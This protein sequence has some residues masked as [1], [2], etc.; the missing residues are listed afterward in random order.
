MSEK[1][2]VQFID[3]YDVLG[4]PRPNS[5]TM[6]HGQCEGTRIV[7]VHRNDVNDEEGEWRR[8]WLVSE[9]NSRTADDYHFVTCPTCGGSGEHIESR[10]A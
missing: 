2:R 4:I 6:C 7:P 3:R 1:M 8:L 10:T 5:E 9:A